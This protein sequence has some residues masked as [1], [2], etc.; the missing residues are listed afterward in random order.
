M[1][2]HVEAT[3]PNPSSR[4]CRPNLVFAVMGETYINRTLHEYRH[5]AANLPP[6]KKLLSTISDLLERLHQRSE[7][8]GIPLPL[9]CRF[10]AGDKP[11][12]LRTVSPVISSETS[13][14]RANFADT[15]KALGLMPITPDAVGGSACCGIGPE[16]R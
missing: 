2:T 6:L 14:Y 15:C 7:E 3:V 4:H 11:H 1:M 9:L 8:T 13:S 12:R 10:K 16:R 5:L